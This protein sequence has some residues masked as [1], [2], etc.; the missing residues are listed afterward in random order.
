M[1][2]KGGIYWVRGSWPGYFNCIEQFGEK[3]KKRLSQGFKSPS[4]VPGKEQEIFMTILKD[5]L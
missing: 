4:Q 2:Y 1:E 5:Y 3:K